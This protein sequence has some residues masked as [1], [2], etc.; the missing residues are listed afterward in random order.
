MESGKP[1]WREIMLVR[2]RCPRFSGSRVTHTSGRDS[3]LRRSFSSVVDLSWSMMDHIYVYG[4]T[5]GL[6]MAIWEYYP[7]MYNIVCHKSDAIVVVMATSPP[8]VSFRWDFIGPWL[9][10]WN[11]LLQR[12]ASAQLSPGSWRI[13][14]ANG[15]FFVNLSLLI[16]ELIITRRFG[17]WTYR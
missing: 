1:S 10:T 12:L 4:R 6:Q 15:T 13:L 9:T 16:Y 8:A 7:A 5:S 3:W 11:A 17:R 2:R 14:H